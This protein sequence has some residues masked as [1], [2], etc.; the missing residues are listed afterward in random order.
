MSASQAV[1]GWRTGDIASAD[2]RTD[3]PPVVALVGRPNVG[4]STFLAALTGR[5]EEAANAPGTTVRPLR[6]EVTLDGRTAIVV[7]MP[8]AYSLADR[9]DGLPPFWQLLAETR[10]DA[11]LSSPG[12]EGAT[13]QALESW[14]PLGDAPT[15]LFPAVTAPD[16]SHP[17]RAPAIPITPRWPSAPPT[18]PPELL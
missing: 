18:P 11:V 9:S 3:R 14:Q 10:P 8:G 12:L 16:H 13:K 5:F 7:D 2:V 15:S 17:Y 4:K 6:R 1:A